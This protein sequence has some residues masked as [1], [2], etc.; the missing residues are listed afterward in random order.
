MS[1]NSKH[2][3][4]RIVLFTGKGG[5]G[6]TSVAAAT[7]FRCSKLGYKTI[8]ISTDTAHSLADSFEFD[9]GPEPTQISEN[10]WGQ[11]ID[12]YYS[13]QKYWGKLQKYMAA[14]FTWRGVESIMAEEIAALPGMEEGSGLLWIEDHYNN[15]D[16]DV[17]IVDCAPTAETLRLLSLPDTGRWWFEKLF[18]IGKRA[19]LMLGPIARPLLDNMPMP[20]EDILDQAEV[21]FNRL[22]ALHQLLID[23]DLSSMRLVVTPEKMVIKEAQRSYTYLNLYG[24]IT[25]SII[26]NRIFPENDGYFSNWKEIQNKYLDLIDNS[27]APLPILKAPYFAHEVL[28]L[29]RLD[30]LAEHIYGDRDPSEILFH[31]K[32]HEIIQK[33][34]G[35]LL[36]IP[37]PFATK[38]EISLFRNND[39]L[40][41][42]AGGWRRNIVLPRALL[43]LTITNA[44]FDN[45][46]LNIQFEKTSE[47]DEND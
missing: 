8:V 33:D 39:E 11:E 3:S 13:I 43:D 23:P 14:V 46:S 19:T 6:K 34:Y 5:V 10:L 4:K 47:E 28:G 25:D 18:P 31:G 29:D 42:Q 37:L 38:E 32:G 15:N 45:S 16:F 41:I 20:D 27:F 2:Q 7:A 36:K 1:S 24:Y 22:D 21:L 9:L 17:I 30:E 40:S 26:C 35:Y 12:V 44:K